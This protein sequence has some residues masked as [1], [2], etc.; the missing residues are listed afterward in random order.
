M[1]EPRGKSRA[2][3]LQQQNTTERFR[4]DPVERLTCAYFNPVEDDSAPCGLAYGYDPSGDGDPKH[5][6]AV[7]TAGTDTF[8]YDPVGN[9]TTRPGATIGYTP[10]DLPKTITQSAG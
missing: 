9:Q 3:A 1:R 8:G 4:Y 5:P 6:H 7:T 2:D 10:F